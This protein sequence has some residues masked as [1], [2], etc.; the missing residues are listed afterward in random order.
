MATAITAK[1]DQILEKRLAQAGEPKREKERLE[2]LELRIRQLENFRLQILAQPNNSQVL[3]EQ[4]RELDLARLLLKIVTEQQNWENLY[5]RFSRDTINI[6]VAGLAR[7]G[8]STY[9]QNVAGLSNNEIP[10][11]DGGPCTSVQSVVFHSTGNPYGR[12]HFYSESSFL[13]EVIRPYYEVLGF[14]SPPRTLAEFRNRTFPPLPTNSPDPAKS[15]SVYKHLR[16][17][18]YQNVDKYAQLLQPQE[19]VETITKDQIKEYVSQEYDKQSKPLFFSHLAVRKVEIFCSF[20]NTEV[21]KI[22]LVDMPGLGDTRLGDTERMIKALGQDVDFILFIR[23]P[24]AQGGFWG[25]PDTDLYDSAY[26]ALRDKLPLE[27]WSFMVLNDDGTNARGCQDMGNTMVSKG[28]K[29]TKS[30]KANCKN[31]D[32]ANLI[33]QEVLIYLTDNIVSLDRQYMS[34][35]QRSL[36][37]LQKEIQAELEKARGILEQ[38]GDG[39]AEYA[40][41]RDIFLRNLYNNIEALRKKFRDEP[42]QADLNFKAQVDAAIQQ[43]SR[44]SGIPPL[45][46]LEGIK[47][48]MGSYA[49]A[50]AYAIH[51]MRPNLLKHFHSVEMGLKESLERKKAEVAEVLINS[52]LGGVTD[53]KGALFLT[54]ISEKVPANLHSLKLGFEFIASFELLYK[55]IIQSMMWQRISAILP[56]DPNNMPQSPDAGQ[57][58]LSDLKERHQKAVESCKEA[59]DGLASSLSRVGVSMIE[60][61]A[62]HITRA[63]GIECEWDIFLGKIRS[64][65][66]KE[67][68]DL[69]VRG[70]LEREWLALIDEATSI[71]QNLGR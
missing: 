6:G 28:I 19:R 71:N 57:S 29:V 40:K 65:V 47:N 26:K 38:Y 45:D 27:E 53:T 44:D 37:E 3:N 18:Y 10:S 66:W 31:A 63:K 17:D 23:R 36:K 43:C 46:E 8:K 32:N 60:E 62:D 56:S 15:E 1:I 20:V 52:G 54:T 64:Q 50:Y 48:R 67:L 69:E 55:G 58:I 33:L 42:P 4:L 34:A 14:S 35:C 22:A 30:F 49:A 7:Q 39:H 13:E 21:G 9:L 2:Q 12:V 68:K 16:D 11:G 51:Q 5:K 70:S 41:L 24:Q 59:L 25:K 61:F